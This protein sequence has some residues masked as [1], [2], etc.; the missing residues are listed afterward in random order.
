MPI[1]EVKS[2]CLKNKG[3]FVC[4]IGFTWT[5]DHGHRIEC[6]GDGHDIC[7]TEKICAEPGLPPCNVP[8]GSLV[9]IYVRVDGGYNKTAHESFIYNPNS[10]CTAEYE[11]TGT[12]L[13]SNLHFLG[14]LCP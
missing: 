7:K 8:A 3:W 6:K 4:H 2:W 11:I 14:I 5:D 10:K 9:T 12:T 1:P 13:D